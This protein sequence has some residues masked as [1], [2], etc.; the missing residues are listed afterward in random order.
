M[1]TPKL[2]LLGLAGV[3]S[4]QLIAIGADAPDAA[5]QA[6]IDVKVK[7]VQAWA[8]DPALV[9]AVKAQNTSLAAD[10]AATG[11]NPADKNKKKGWF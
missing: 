11:A 8:A 3:T 1:R 6:K 10:A 4:L 9:N 5:L 7:E 2:A